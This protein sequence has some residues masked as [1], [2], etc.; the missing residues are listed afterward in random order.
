MLDEK[1]AGIWVASATYSPS[2]IINCIE[3]V[4]RVLDGEEADK[5]AVIPTTIVDKDNVADFLDENTP[6]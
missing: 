1:Y 6:Y 4:I 3:N 2:M 5:L